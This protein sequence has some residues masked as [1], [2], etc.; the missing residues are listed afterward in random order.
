MFEKPRLLV[1]AGGTLVAALLVILMQDTGSG[2]PK[3]P[4]S[5]GAEEKIMK[6]E[7][8]WR[9][10]LTPE[11][12]HVTRKKG[13]ERPF[14]GEY[15]DSKKKG[16]YRCVCCGQEL[17]GS[18]TKFDSGSGWPSF[19]APSSEK[20]VREVADKSHGMVRTEVV[21]AR[22]DAH[23]GHVFDDGPAPT[24]LR[25]CI[26]SVSLKF[27]E[28]EKAASAS[29][30]KGQKAMFGAGCFWGVEA[31]FRQ[32]EGVIDA[33]AGYSGGH[34]ENPTY[35]QVC[36]DRTG[37]AEVVLV[38]YDPEKITYE[39]LLDVFWN[40]HNPTQ[41]NRQGPDVGKQ[42]RSAIFYFGEEQKKIAEASK[43]RLQKSGQYKRNIATEITA[44]STFY[45]AEEY[46]QR[47]LEKRGLKGCSRDALYT[48]SLRR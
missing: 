12:F 18:S 17:F 44:A 16:L 7:A 1:V 2:D 5:H 33:A 24:G 27:V 15:V 45:R 13:T 41:L 39:K 8:E 11:Q 26:N 35:K 34:T 10:L 36:T 30:Q 29:E 28:G 9:K 32:T 21:C 20:G 23:L 31:T 42:Y 19:Y 47:Y 22:C 37:H 46:H 43:E 25:Y 3:A 4:Q 48:E 14:T 38:T 40:C 6:T